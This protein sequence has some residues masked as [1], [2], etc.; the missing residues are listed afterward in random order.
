M[1][2]MTS[3]LRRKLAPSRPAAVPGGASVEALLRKLMPRDADRE[4]RLDL[5]VGAVTLGTVP[6]TAVTDRLT[7][8]DLAFLM[9]GPGDTRGLC[10]MTPGLLAALTEVQMSGRVTRSAPPDRIPTRTDGIVVAEMLDRWMRSALEAAEEAGLTDILPFAGYAR[11]DGVQPRRNVVLAL[12]P[13]EYR[14]LSVD[15]VL[16]DDAKTGTLFFAM[17][18][19]RPLTV[20]SP[21]PGRM[22]RHLATVP[23]PMTAVLARL[24]HPYGQARRLGVGDLIPIPVS[25]LVNVRLETLAGKLIATARLGQLNGQKAVRLSSGGGAAAA[26]SG[27]PISGARAGLAGIAGATPF[28]GLAE[29]PGLPDLPDLPDFPDLPDLPDLPPLD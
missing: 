24:P 28:P 8:L 17:P 29:L 5:M 7:A 11:M 20:V 4:L 21:Q 18:V 10:L 25:A 6:K 3:V 1:N 2:D 27:P 15:L 22:L 23:A 26:L 14:T 9:K 13:V 12:D 19:P 16:G